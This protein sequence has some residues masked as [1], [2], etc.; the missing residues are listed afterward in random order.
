MVTLSPS[1]IVISLVTR[2]GSSSICSVGPTS[3]SSADG[4]TALV[5]S[6]GSMRACGIF[7]SPLTTISRPAIL[8]LRSGDAS[9]R[10]S[11]TST[12]RRFSPL[13][14]SRRTAGS[15]R[16]SILPE[17]ASVPAPAFAVE[18]NSSWLDGDARL[19]VD[20]AQREVQLV[21]IELGIADSLMTPEARGSP[22][23]PPKRQVGVE[24]AG[25]AIDVRQVQRDE[26]ELAG[27]HLQLAAHRPTHHV[28]AGALARAR[29]RRSGRA[30]RRRAAPRRSSRR[31][32]P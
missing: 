11:G 12:T 31:A 9:M 16:H 5:R 27:R 21:E 13:T 10:A 24:V 23:V 2:N 15:S 26:A 6:A 25:R 4:S 18:L 22:S 3:R 29:G 20:V 32:R 14:R 1:V 19:H 7:T 8:K 28:G 30:A 17:L